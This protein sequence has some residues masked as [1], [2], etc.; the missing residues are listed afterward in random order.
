MHEQAQLRLHKDEIQK[1]GAAVYVVQVQNVF[2]TK[3]FK[4]ENRLLS[5]SKRSPFAKEKNLVFSTALADPAGR[6]SAIYGVSR[7]GVRW[8]EWVENHPCWFII[9]R[10]GVITYKAHP[11]FDQPGATYV[12]E[13][14]AVM[15]ALRKAAK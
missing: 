5:K 6:A 10:E 4:T 12:K 3:V 1:L 15:Q 8:Y 2:R 13:V 9:N 11:R 7:K 14:N